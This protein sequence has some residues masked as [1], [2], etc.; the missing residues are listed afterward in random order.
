MDQHATSINHCTI[1]IH[2]LLSVGWQQDSLGG[3][4]LS[5][6]P[7]RQ[8][9]GGST[10]HMGRK[11]MKLQQTVHFSI[12]KLILDILL[13]NLKLK[14]SKT[15][16]RENKR[17][18]IGMVPGKSTRGMGKWTTRMK[19]S[20]SYID[21]KKWPFLPTASQIRERG[22]TSGESSSFLPSLPFS[23]VREQFELSGRFSIRMFKCSV[24]MCP[25]KSTSLKAKRTTGYSKSKFLK[26]FLKYMQ[27]FTLNRC[28]RPSA[29]S[30]AK[31]LQL[32]N[33]LH[34]VCYGILEMSMCTLRW[35]QSAAV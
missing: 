11:V 21:L 19:S 10:A 3:S 17:N 6:I 7:F 9:W 2:M 15:Q 30:A 32:S 34:F 1:R 24:H 14:R 35:H 4:V 16:G 20:Y 23:F 12:P 13:I 8:H 22:V 31:L 33:Y 29:R 26:L 25:N 5:I 27:K 28:F 18:N